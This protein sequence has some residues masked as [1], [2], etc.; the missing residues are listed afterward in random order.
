MLD[1]SPTH[2]SPHFHHNHVVYKVNKILIYLLC[3]A[4]GTWDAA[5]ISIGEE[6]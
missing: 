1:L 6:N 4:A 3:C 2:P 5:L